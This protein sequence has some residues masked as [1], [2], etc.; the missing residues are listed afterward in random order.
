MNYK[1]C[2][3]CG[4]K[5]L[6]TEFHQKIEGGC[7]HGR[8]SKCKPCRAQYN[9]DNQAIIAPQRR[10][11]YQENKE[12][13]LLSN[14]EFY[15]E[16]RAAHLAQKKEYNARYYKE[17]KDKVNERKKE[18]ERK[19]NSTEPGCIYQ[20]KNRLNDRYYIGETT[21]G[22]RRWEEHLYSL[23]TQ[24]HTNPL[25][26]A[27]YDK[28]G[29]EAFEWKILKEMTKDKEKLLKEEIKTIQRCIEEG[30][31]L[32]NI[33]LTLQQLKMLLEDK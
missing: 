12:R 5:K 10:K 21:R 6:L 4:E 3:K 29:V 33:Q 19:K 32:Y 15:Y 30:K 8:R 18:Y 13:I 22:R 16:N 28:F 27:D 17:N 2:T 1:T 23:K 25:L 9:S 26:Q 31:E 24:R 14:R 20:I 7:K 11:H